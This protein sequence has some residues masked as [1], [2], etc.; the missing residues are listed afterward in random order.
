MY[1][2]QRRSCM[3]FCFLV[4]KYGNHDFMRKE[5]QRLNNRVRMYDS[6]HVVQH[7]LHHYILFLLVLYMV[8]GAPVPQGEKLGCIDDESL[9]R[10]I[11][12]FKSFFRAGLQLGEFIWAM[13]SKGSKTQ[14]SLGLSNFGYASSHNRQCHFQFSKKKRHIFKLEQEELF[15]LSDDN[16]LILEENDD[17]I[18]PFTDK[19]WV[20]IKIYQLFLGN[21]KSRPYGAL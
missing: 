19:K 20:L 4:T 3:R 18:V 14:S 12:V 5:T 6:I 15:G 11:I 2:I 1:I 16:K 10:F 9:I 21:Y 17:L 13:R 8:S 7:K